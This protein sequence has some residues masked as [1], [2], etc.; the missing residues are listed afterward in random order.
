MKKL[1]WLWLIIIIYAGC[2]Y[3]QT[4]NKTITLPVNSGIIAQ[5]NDSMYEGGLYG[6][7]KY[8]AQGNTYK[9]RKWFSFGVTGIPENATIS[10]V[11][12]I[13][14]M[15]NTDASKSFKLTQLESNLGNY[16]Q[17]WNN[18]GN[19]NAHHTGL[20]YGDQN[21]YSN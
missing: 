18:I 1:K 8:I 6:I 14:D 13:Y 4:I 2:I 19:G 16:Q 10:Q 9:E 20:V 12:V 7:G 5:K 17:L 21:F 11:Q 15:S 3:S